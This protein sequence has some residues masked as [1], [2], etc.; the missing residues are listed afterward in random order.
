MVA[1]LCSVVLGAVLIALA[2]AC[3]GDPEEGRKATREEA[4]EACLAYAEVSCRKYADCRGESEES[5]DGCLLLASQRC[6]RQVDEITCWDGL[7]DGYE[8]CLTVEDAACEDLCD[9]DGVCLH[10]CFFECPAG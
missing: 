2:A 1:R 4:Q 7:R 10:S 5:I 9:E 8:E 3:A 6:G